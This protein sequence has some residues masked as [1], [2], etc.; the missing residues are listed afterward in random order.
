ML[1]GSAK[2]E[3]SVA[4]V[5]K[6]KLNI[7]SGQ[8]QFNHFVDNA[9]EPNCVKGLRN[10]KKQGFIM[11]EIVKCFM[12]V[13]NSPKQLVRRGIFRPKTKLL[14][15]VSVTFVTVLGNCVQIFYEGMEVHLQVYNS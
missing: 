4:K 10:I 11:L 13:L 2:G 9:R 6:N 15:H 7:C 14:W 3:Y 1:I 12:N 5:R 8:L